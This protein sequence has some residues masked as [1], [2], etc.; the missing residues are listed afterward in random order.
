MCLM[1]SAKVGGSRCHAHERERERE[2][3]KERDD[4]DTHAT[5]GGTEAT[6]RTIRLLGE[7]RRRA[8]PAAG[9]ALVTFSSL[10]YFNTT[11]S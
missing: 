9:V 5:D 8:A 11:F 6:L 7:R 4:L 1:K 2:R 3:E 10:P